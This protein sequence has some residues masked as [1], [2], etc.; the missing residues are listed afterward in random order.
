ME[1][2]RHRAEDAAEERVLDAL[3]PGTASH[4]LRQ[5]SGQAAEPRAAPTP[6]R[7][8]A[9]C[10]ARANSTTEIEIEVAR[11][12]MG[13]E[14]MAPPGMEEMTSQLQGCSRTSAAARARAS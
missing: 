8:S 6:G 5:P 9:R 7:N 14:I 10:C 3:L 13:V 1:K 2:V 12:P 4:R 11:V